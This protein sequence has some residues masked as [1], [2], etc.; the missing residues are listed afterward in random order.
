M[1]QFYLISPSISDPI[2][3]I[4]KMCYVSFL[5][6]EE[7]DFICRANAVEPEK[8]VL[9]DGHFP[10]FKLPLWLLTKFCVANLG[11]SASIFLRS[12]KILTTLRGSVIRIMLK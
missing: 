1:A 7:E 6:G 10:R 12:P 11:S 9:V 8:T 2:I 5:K 4:S 3:Q